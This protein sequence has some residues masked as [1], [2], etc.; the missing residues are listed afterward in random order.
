MSRFLEEKKEIFRSNELLNEESAHFS[1]QC[2]ALEIV[3]NCDRGYRNFVQNIDDSKTDED[4]IN[5]LRYLN[6]LEKQDINMECPLYECIPRARRPE[7][8]FGDFEPPD[9]CGNSITESKNV[10]D[11]VKTKLS[12]LM[13]LSDIDL[14]A[15]TFIRNPEIITEYYFEEIIFGLCSGIK[16]FYEGFE[17]ILDKNEVFE[18]YD[19]NRILSMSCLRSKRLKQVSERNTRGN[20][21][22]KFTNF[23]NELGYAYK[24]NFIE[25]E[26]N[27]DIEQ[28]SKIVNQEYNLRVFQNDISHLEI[29]RCMINQTNCFDNIFYMHEEKVEGLEI[30]IFGKYN[31]EISVNGFREYLEND[32]KMK[33]EFSSGSLLEEKIWLINQRVNGNIDMHQRIELTENKT[34][35]DQDLLEQLIPEVEIIPEDKKLAK[36]VDDGQVSDADLLNNE[37]E[38]FEIF[39]EDFGICSKQEEPQS[40]SSPKKKKSKQS[41]SSPSVEFETFL[42]L[43]KSTKCSGILFDDRINFLN[44]ANQ[45]EIYSTNTPKATQDIEVKFQQIRNRIDIDNEEIWEFFD[46]ICIFNMSNYCSDY[47]EFEAFAESELNVMI[48]RRNQNEFQGRFEVDLIVS[49]DLCVIFFDNISIKQPDEIIEQI[50]KAMFEFAKI[51][52]FICHFNSENNEISVQDEDYMRITQEIISTIQLFNFTKEAENKFFVKHI[53]QGESI[54]FDLTKYLYEILKFEKKPDR[55]LIA[56]GFHLNE[57][58]VLKEQA[59]S[60]EIKA[61]Y[62]K[63]MNPYKYYMFKRNK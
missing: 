53:F 21:L 5:V 56:N 33:F 4:E 24:I 50:S 52:I 35:F 12:Q 44:C 51:V 48:F 38:D 17:N 11:S 58:D 55:M 61:C 30:D 1:S 36:L 6:S 39:F 23:E 49:P 19:G 46:G 25:T 3:A 7:D 57:I 32:E 20:E 43:R 62:C 59:Q 31:F 40:L 37:I 15:S 18:S 27:K 22:R 60:D 45:N 63:G 10:E 47:I 14:K 16:L 2:L 13:M 28:I 54:N 26:I 29:L 42:K 9:V 41:N 8:L 34:G